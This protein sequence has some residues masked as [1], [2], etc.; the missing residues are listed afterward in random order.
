LTR[1]TTQVSFLP[2]NVKK[3]VQNGNG[4]WLRC[5]CL[6]FIEGKAAGETVRNENGKGGT[7]KRYS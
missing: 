4:V 7:L 6:S 2:K 3:Q 1:T 5:D